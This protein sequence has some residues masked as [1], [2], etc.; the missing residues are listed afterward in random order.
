MIIF[1]YGEDD[2]RS[3]EKLKEIKEKFIRSDSR[4]AGLSVL[5]LSEK[6]ESDVISALGSLGLFSAKR[7]IIIKNL[8][9]SGAKEKQDEIQRH[10]EKNKNISSD[11]DLVVVFWEENMPRK[12]N[13]LYKF[14]D[15]KAEGI[16][17]QNFEK[18]ADKKIEQWILKKI[19]EREK[20]MKISRGA[21]GKLVIYAGNDTRVLAGEVKKLADFCSSGMIDESAVELLVKS[22]ISG[23]IFSTIDAIA[24]N[25]KKKAISL[26][27]NHLEQGEDPFYLFS[28]FTYQFRNLLKIAG[29]AEKDISN[30]YEISKL[31][32]MH[33]FV[34]KKS[35]AQLRNFP[36]GKL[37]NIYAALADLDQK[38]KTGKIDIRLA[39]QKFLVE[40]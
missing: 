7:L 14:L 30:E 21:L 15:S 39:L 2:F 12:N 5:D 40:L 34:V 33:P 37:K 24:E 18:L 31:A 29:F 27:Q 10:L 17:K 32:K 6:P 36:A 11:A 28:M 22:N 8:I 13:A 4:G 1:L 3:S 9:F 25:N 38:I 23:N 35:L 19:A 26:L 20:E 16:K